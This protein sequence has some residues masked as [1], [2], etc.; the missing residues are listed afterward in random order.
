MNWMHPE[1]ILFTSMAR[2]KHRKTEQDHASLWPH[3]LPNSVGCTSVY[4]WSRSGWNWFL[5]RAALFLIIEN[6]ELWVF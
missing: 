5:L 6:L 2:D 3:P 4:L 1:V